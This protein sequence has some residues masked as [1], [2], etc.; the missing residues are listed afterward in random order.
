MMDKKETILLTLEVEIS[1][2]TTEARD[3]AIERILAK[4]PTIEF[5]SADG[6]NNYHYRVVGV[7]GWDYK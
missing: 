4:P 7:D 2:T 3:R 1:Y 6:K 5:S